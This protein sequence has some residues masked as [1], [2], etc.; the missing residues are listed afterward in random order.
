MDLEGDLPDPDLT[1]EGLSCHP[2][3]SLI[4]FPTLAILRNTSCPAGEQRTFQQPLHWLG[5]LKTRLLPHKFT[6]T[7]HSYFFPLWIERPSNS[8]HIDWPHQRSAS[9]PLSRHG[10][11]VW[12]C[13]SE[14]SP[15]QGSPAAQS[16]QTTYPF[17]TPWDM[18]AE[19]SNNPTVV[20]RSRE[21]LMLCNIFSS[22]A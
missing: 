10:K 4:V 13:Y 12:L 18:G 9:S 6:I 15:T 17:T 20:E 2:C 16:H 22:F 5:Q 19:F 1:P 11:Q 3:P 14:F 7:P 21:R 8:T